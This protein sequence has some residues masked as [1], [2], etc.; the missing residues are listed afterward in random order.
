MVENKLLD[1]LRF[2]AAGKELREH[3]Q[4]NINGARLWVLHLTTVLLLSNLKYSVFK[5][6]LLS[7]LGQSF[8]EY[9]AEYRLYFSE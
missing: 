5:I 6:V 7:S 8:S 4:P 3:Q 1:E 9:S 2:G